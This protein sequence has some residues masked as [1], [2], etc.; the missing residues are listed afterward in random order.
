MPDYYIKMARGSITVACA[1]NMVD[2]DDPDPA[3]ITDLTEDQYEPDYNSDN[4]EVHSQ[5]SSGKELT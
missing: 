5:T 1:S 2:F 3:T 4:D